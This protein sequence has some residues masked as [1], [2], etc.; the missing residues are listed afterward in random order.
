MEPFVFASIAQWIERDGTDSPAV[1]VDHLQAMLSDVNRVGVA[2]T[3]GGFSTGVALPPGFTP[4]SPE[5]SN[6]FEKWI[7]RMAARKNLDYSTFF[8]AGVGFT[9]TSAKW[10]RFAIFP[11]KEW[12][13]TVY[14]QGRTYID[15]KGDSTKL[16]PSKFECELG[17]RHWVYN[18]DE[19][20]LRGGVA[21]VVES[22]L[23]VLSLKRE[24]AIRGITGFV[25][26]A[27]FKHKVSQ[28][29]LHKLA[30]CKGL[31]EVCMLYDEDA[32]SSVYAECRRLLGRVKMTY[33][34]MPHKVDAN[35]D[36]VLAVDGVLKRQT[37]S[38]SAALL[39]ALEIVKP[40]R[41]PAADA[42]THTKRHYS[43]SRSGRQ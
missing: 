24:F 32:I 4:L 29:Q 10:E 13:R 36:A 14:Y 6:V 31:K 1:S 26:V 3:T 23:N 27:V 12:G 17:A 11:V 33:V 43:H 5:P 25:P 30:A 7:G 18:I 42:N 39:D 15:I 2:R 19:L 16:F 37:Y 34:K 35:D 9:R 8:E 28:E 38:D 22:I 21:V 41:S 40:S 20:R